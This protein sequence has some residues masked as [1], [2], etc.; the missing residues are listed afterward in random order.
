MIKSQ[1]ALL[2]QIGKDSFQVFI[3]ISEKKKVFEAKFRG[4]K[5]KK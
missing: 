3:Q 5:D 2:L 1:F 4:R